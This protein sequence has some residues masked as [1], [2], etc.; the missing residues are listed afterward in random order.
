VQ[1]LLSHGAL[2]SLENNV[3]MQAWDSGHHPCS[4]RSLFSQRGETAAHWTS[5]AGIE[6]LLMDVRQI[7]L[8]C[9]AR[10]PNELS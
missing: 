9:A 1:L 8:C 4:S 5:D 3:S 10:K 2:A 6:N 7:Q